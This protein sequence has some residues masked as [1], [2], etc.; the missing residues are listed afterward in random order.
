MLRFDYKNFRKDGDTVT[1]TDVRFPSYY[2][3]KFIARFKHVPKR[4]VS[5]LKFLVKNF[6]QEEYFNRLTNGEAPLTIL[7][8]KGYQF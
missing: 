4:R 3:Y 2:D 7:M 1:Y 6:T 8:S 5:F